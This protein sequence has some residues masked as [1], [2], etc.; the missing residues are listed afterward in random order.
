MGEAKRRGTATER[1]LAQ[2]P[3][4]CFCGGG[5]PATTREHYPPKALF[6]NSHRPDQLVVPAC[7][8]CNDISRSAD[9]IVGIAS[10][11]SFSDLNEIEAQDHKRLARRLST[12]A[13]QIASEWL[14]ASRRIMQKRARRHLQQQGVPVTHEEGYVTLGPQTIPHLHLFAH[15]LTIAIHFDQTRAQTHNQ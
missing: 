13:P 4:C 7:Q 12:Q 2:H 5:T 1:L 8:P 14:S 10:R 11:W 9:L 15:K 3:Y 6:D